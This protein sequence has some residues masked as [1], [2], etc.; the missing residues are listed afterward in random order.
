MIRIEQEVK[1]SI[2]KKALEGSLAV[3][4][5]AKGIVLFAHGSGSGRFSPRNRYVAKVLN[6]TGLATMLVDLLTKEEEHVD[7]ATGE[8]RFNI[9]LLSGRLVT[10]TQW[11]KKKPETKDL[12]LGYFG[13][14][15]GAAAAI[16]AATKFP[17]AIRAIVL[18]GGRPDLAMAYLHLV[19]APVL[20]IVGG[21]DPVVMDLNKK[22][23]GE[24]QVD[25]KLEVVPGATHLFE[26]PGRLEQ[27]ARLSAAWFLTHLN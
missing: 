12:A 25:K 15:T 4:S 7:I 18:R 21:R 3:P 26:E 16:I 19:R 1:I 23:M 13:S 5:D 8:F 14:S 2:D 11:L 22:A 27:V 24:I 20:F 6:E 17:E 10:A 9:D